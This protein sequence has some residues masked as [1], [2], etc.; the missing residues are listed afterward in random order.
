MKSLSRHKLSSCCVEEGGEDVSEDNVD[1]TEELVS[2]MNARRCHSNANVVRM[3]EASIECMI[4]V[5]N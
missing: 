2:E 1:T 4:D 3:L 5:S